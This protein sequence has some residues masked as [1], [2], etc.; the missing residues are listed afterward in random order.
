MNLRY[1]RGERSLLQKKGGP[2]SII[3]FFMNSKHRQN[4]IVMSYSG[5]RGRL[6]GK[7]HDVTLLGTE[8]ISVFFWVVV[9]QLHAAVSIHGLNI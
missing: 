2:S 4:Y 3:S 1:M 9:T 5:W 6:A 8:M 7:E